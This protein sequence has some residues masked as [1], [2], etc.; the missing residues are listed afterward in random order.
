[1]ISCWI[2]Y[3][4]HKWTD[5]KSCSV[6][7]NFLVYQIKSTITARRKMDGEKRKVQRGDGRSMRRNLDG[8]CW[9]THRILT[10]H[11]ETYMWK[12]D[13]ELLM[14]KWLQALWEKRPRSQWQSTSVGRFPKHLPCSSALLCYKPPVDQVRNMRQSSWRRNIPSQNIIG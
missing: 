10:C 4:R 13:R 1:M 9:N 2:P 12:E 3:L 7:S 6:L 14:M 11:K 5:V 8:N